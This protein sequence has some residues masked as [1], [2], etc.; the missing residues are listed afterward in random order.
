MAS[1]SEDVWAIVLSRGL[2]TSEISGEAS[3][4]SMTN[5]IRETNANAMRDLVDSLN[6]LIPI[7]R[8][9]IGCS[10]SEVVEFSRTL[11]NI[12]DSNFLVEPMSKDTG[13]IIAMATSLI[14]NL[15][16]EAVL[17]VVSSN[18][19]SRFGPETQSALLAGTE[20]ARL[21]S[22]I[23][24]GR[25]VSILDVEARTDTYL[26]RTDEATLVGNVELYDVEAR[27]SKADVS[28]LRS[29][30]DTRRLFINSG[31]TIW[32]VA[33]ML[34]LLVQLQ[35]PLIGIVRMTGMDWRNYDYERA[36]HFAWS[37]IEN[38]S[39][40]EDVLPFTNDLQIVSTNWPMSHET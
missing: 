6:I 9:L 21:G 4:E 16:T 2:D 34:N 12:P 20:A 7:T 10:K 8:V 32:R 40:N 37:S 15:N 13:P 25:P 23:V 38:V 30:G 24:V 33:T 5:E 39:L 27:I 31:I 35:S 28:D 29:L 22:I 18:C 19:N 3:C 11:K 17:I 14:H 36:S 1:S 26:A